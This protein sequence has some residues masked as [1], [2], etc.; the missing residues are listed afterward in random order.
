[1]RNETVWIGSAKTSGDHVAGYMM[2]PPPPQKKNNEN[3]NV[4]SFL[5][6]KHMYLYRRES[7]NKE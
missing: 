5:Q 7:D 4:F 3:H 2:I 6:K 1:M